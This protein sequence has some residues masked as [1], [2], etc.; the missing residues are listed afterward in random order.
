MKLCYEHFH[1]IFITF[2]S[3]RKTAT[4]E[5]CESAKN[6]NFDALRSNAMD[7]YQKVCTGFSLSASGM[8]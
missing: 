2:W 6:I 3:V 8:L 4:Q 5:W 7:F 1:N